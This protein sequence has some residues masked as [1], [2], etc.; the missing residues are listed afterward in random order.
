MLDCLHLQRK[1]MQNTVIMVLSPIA[2]NSYLQK[3]GPGY[4]SVSIF[5]FPFIHELVCL[6]YVLSQIGSMGEIVFSS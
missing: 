1:A 2:C 6:G 5:I 3:D 4:S